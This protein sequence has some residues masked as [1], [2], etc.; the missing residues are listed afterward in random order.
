M[1]EPS[2]LPGYDALCRQM[3]GREP[4]WMGYA[5]EPRQSWVRRLLAWLRGFR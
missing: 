3:Q 4:E 1:S 5:V 2:L